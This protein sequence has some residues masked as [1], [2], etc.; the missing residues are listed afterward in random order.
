MKM[1]ERFTAFAAVCVLAAGFFSYKGEPEDIDKAPA[2]C[3]RPPAEV[4][5]LQTA[6]GDGKISL[7]WKNPADADLHQLEI[8]TE[9][10]D[11]TL[12]HPVY[13]AATK[14]AADSSIAEA[15]KNGTAYTFTLRTIDNGLN[16]SKGAKSESAA[17]TKMTHTEELANILH[18]S[19]RSIQPEIRRGVAEHETAASKRMCE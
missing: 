2:P 12:K 7:I 16:K 5:Q 6:A 18:K 1:T 17:G 4:T 8:R 13:L 10:A 15:L 3:K 11:G 14:D 9:L 19:R